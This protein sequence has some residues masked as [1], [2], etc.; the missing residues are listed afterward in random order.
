M[1]PSIIKTSILNFKNN[2]LLLFIPMGIFYLLL[3][4]ALFGALAM[5]VQGLTDTLNT[6]VALI[7]TSAEQSSASVNDFLAYSFGQLQWNGS[8]LDIVRQIS[9]MGW[10]QNTLTGFFATLNASTQG[11]EEQF[12][13]IVQ[14][15]ADT[16]KLSVTFA[17]VLG[18]AGILLAHYATHYA[19]R[20]KTVKSNLK[21]FLFAR[22]VIP[23]VQTLLVIAA[24]ILLSFTK[25][26]GIFLLI[27]LLLISSGISLL[28]SWLVHRD[29]TLKLKDI[30]T[31]RN[32]LSQLA[33]L[34]L[35]L[36]VD[37]AVAGL[38]LLINPLLAV[39]IMVPVLIY[40]LNIA[41]V[42][43]DSFICA[44]IEQQKGA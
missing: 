38:L 28:S 44:Q 25:L 31:V 30:F 37:M 17:A 14:G 5:L 4:I 11:F 33:V 6:L 36:L 32:L 9:D 40:S 13:A 21:K 27:A 15:F 43:T 23:F 35:L 20:R 39:L 24:L 1:K 10:L 12:T 18:A 7:K 42:N 8:F 34:G 3:L 19:V 41:D 2:L 26:Y 29:K 16:V 22:L